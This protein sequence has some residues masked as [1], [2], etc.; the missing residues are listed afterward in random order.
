MGNQVWSACN[1]GATTANADTGTT[2][3][4]TTVGSPTWYQRYGAYYQWGR[5]VD[6]T[7]ATGFTGPVS[8]DGGTGFIINASSPYDWLATQ[9]DNLWG[10]QGTASTAGTF[11]SKG[12]PSAM[13]GPCPAGYHVPTQYEWWQT[14]STLN[15]ALAN[16]GSWQNDT[17][18]A[19]TLKLPLVGSRNDSTA[20]YGSQGVYGFYWSAS[21]SGTNGY[22]IGISSTQ[23]YLLGLKHRAFGVGVRCLKN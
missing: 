11:T 10:G 12:S 2:V 14:L 21:L 17:S 19:T 1:A 6:V 7:T 13:Q 16:T 18:I 3:S 4:G 22:S 20:A 8:V 9:N 15:P 5:N 23:V